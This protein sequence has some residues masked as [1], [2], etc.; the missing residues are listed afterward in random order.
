MPW[1]RFT[2]DHSFIPPEKRNM[3][4]TYRQGMVRLVR[5]VCADDAIAKGRAT[6]TERPRTNDV[7]RGIARARSV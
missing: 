2:S 5:R 6:L 4:I 3:I 7:G 1:V